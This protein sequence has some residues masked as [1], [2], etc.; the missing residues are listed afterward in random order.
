[1]PLRHSDSRISTPILG[2]RIVRINVSLIVMQDGDRAV[3][4]QFQI[5]QEQF[6]EY[7]SK[8]LIRAQRQYCVIGGEPLAIVE[9]VKYFLQKLYGISFFVRTEHVPFPG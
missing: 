7:I 6:T 2:F 3:L 8:T 5:C 4:S 9:A 1:M